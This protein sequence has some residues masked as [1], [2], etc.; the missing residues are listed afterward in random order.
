MT[1]S[2]HGRS[3]R[4][5]SRPPSSLHQE[6]PP[7]P[8]AATE[9]EDLDVQSVINER[10]PSKLKPV[11]AFTTYGH[12]YVKEESAA[13][14]AEQHQKQEEQLKDVTP[15]PGP[16]SVELSI[17]VDETPSVDDAQQETQDS[18]LVVLVESNKETTNGKKR[19]KST[20]GARDETDT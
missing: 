4:E 1:I 14:T 20:N 8:A 9:T 2:S 15:V 3:F 12:L 11:T 6:P 7:Q 13:E 5:D 17:F 18:D 19:K 10:R 16:S